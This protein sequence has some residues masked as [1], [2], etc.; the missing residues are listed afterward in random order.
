MSQSENDKR[1]DYVELPASDV[2]AAKG[3][4]SDVFG[5]EFTDYGPDYTSF[6]DGRLDGGFTNA[7]EAAERGPLVVIYVAD[8]EACMESVQKRGGD[9]HQGHLRFPW[10]PPLP[11]H[12]P[13][14]Q[15]TGGV[16]G[17][18][19]IAPSPRDDVR[20]GRPA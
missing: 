6:K 17:P 1:I 10:G 15:R 11:L 9:H 4:Y 8:L 19:V 18:G 14:R 3:F 20:R 2:A 16:V 7:P 5:W 13:G 12:R